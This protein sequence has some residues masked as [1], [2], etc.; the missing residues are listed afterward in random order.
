MTLNVP[1]LGFKGYATVRSKSDQS[2]QHETALRQ[3]LMR[4]LSGRDTD[5]RNQR[6]KLFVAVNILS[7]VVRIT[8]RDKL[9]WI[10]QSRYP[11]DGPSRS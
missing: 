8:Q 2:M 6:S 3:V 7:K 10:N 4:I 11:L 1:R 5:V 9:C